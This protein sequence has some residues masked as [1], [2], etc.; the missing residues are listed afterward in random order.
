MAEG[1]STAL[2]SRESRVPA[3]TG[4]RFL[5]LEALRGLAALTVV[6][7]HYKFF[8]HVQVAGRFAVDLFFVMSGFVIAHAY[9]AKLARGMSFGDFARARLIRLYPMYL[10]AHF[11]GVVVLYFVYGGFSTDTAMFFGLFMLPDPRSA[12]FLFPII[13]IAWSLLDELAVNVVYGVSWPY[14]TTRNLAIFTV[15]A[16]AFLFGAGYWLDGF[17]QGMSWEYGWVGF[18]RIL[19]AFPLGVLI[20]NLRASSRLRLRAPTALILIAPLPLFWVWDFGAFA[21][22]ASA[23]FLFVLTPA[24]V[25]AAVGS[26]PPAA[27]R[28]FCRALGIISYP[29]YL[30]QVAFFHPTAVLLNGSIGPDRYIAGALMLLGFCWIC[31]ALDQY[32]DAPFRRLLTRLTGA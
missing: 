11:G 14:W 16:A 15:F 20:H 17:N 6:L 29:A 10:L 22:I 28:G 27:L 32:V 18:A 2:V 25:V 5:H 26:E 31:W 23:I 4:D 1:I 21:F 12:D 3:R 9:S 7:E 13:P 24:L 30:L 8:P 19:Y